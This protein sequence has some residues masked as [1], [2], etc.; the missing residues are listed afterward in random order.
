MCRI[1]IDERNTHTHHS[2]SHATH[3]HTYTHPHMH[4]HTRSLI[5]IH[6]HTLTHA[7]THSLTN[8]H[9]HIHTLT[10]THLQELQIN[11]QNYRGCS[12]YN[13]PRKKKY[14]KMSFRHTKYFRTHGQSLHVEQ[15]VHR[16]VK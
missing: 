8:S 16:L 15:V 4:I 14:F 13:I 6:T 3:A 5:H 1:L 2:Y 9:T 7:H 10:H 12:R 11:G